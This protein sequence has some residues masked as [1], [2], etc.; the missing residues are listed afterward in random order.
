MRFVCDQDVDASVAALLRRRGHEAWTV[1]SAGLALASDDDLTVYA[2]NHDSA[3]I[4]HDIEFSQR[5]RRSV[6]GRHVFLR[7]NEWDAAQLL[8]KHLNEVVSRFSRRRDLW[9]KLSQGRE[10]TWSQDWR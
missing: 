1:G 6:A 4:T 7:C 9:V 10:P 3:L 2:D 8:D 5:R